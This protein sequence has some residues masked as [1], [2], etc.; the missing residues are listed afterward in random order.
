MNIWPAEGDPHRE[1]ARAAPRARN[2]HVGDGHAA[3]QP[4][5]QREPGENQ[6]RLAILVPHR[7]EAKTTV[8]ETGWP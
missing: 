3:H 6:Q 4:E 5:Q 7:R 8:E 2:E 1:L